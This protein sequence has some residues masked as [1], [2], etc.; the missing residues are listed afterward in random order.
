MIKLLLFQHIRD[1]NKD[2]LSFLSTESTQVICPDP[3][4]ADL[5]RNM[6]SSIGLEVITFND[7]IK[8]LSHKYDVKEEKKSKSEILF[9]LNLAHKQIATEDRSFSSLMRSYNLLSELRSVTLDSSVID[10]ILSLFDE[11][12]KKEVLS[13]NLLLENLNYFDEHSYLDLLSHKIKNEM[14]NKNYLFIGF[15]FFN[16]IQIDF[17]KTLSQVT[18]AYFA[19]P[20]TLYQK[21]SV[22]DWP[23]WLIQDEDNEV[24]ELSSLRNEDYKFYLFDGNINSINVDNHQDCL[25]FIGSHLTQENLQSL[26]SCEKKMKIKH[27][28]LSLSLEWQRYRIWEIWDTSKGSINL[29]IS[30]VSDELMSLIKKQQFLDIE[31]FKNFMTYLETMK[32]DYGVTSLDATD[33]LLLMELLELD[34]TR[35]SLHSMNTS[36]EYLVVTDLNSVES[37][38]ISEKSVMTIF[39]S[40]LPLKKNISLYKSE[41]EKFLTTIGPIKTSSFS[42]QLIISKVQTCLNQGARIYFEKDVLSDPDFHEIFPSYIK[43]ETVEIEKSQKALIQFSQKEGEL[44]KRILS[45]S[46][47]QTY[48]DCPLKFKMQYEEGVNYHNSFDHVISALED[49]NFLH[50]VIE[51]YMK[52]HTE[53]IQDEFEKYYHG[54][55]HSMFKEKRLSESQIKTNFLQ[56]KN[57]LIDNINFLYQIFD[58]FGLSD[59][60]FEKRIQNPTMNGIV[61]FYAETQDLIVLLD[62]K[63]SKSSIPSKKGLMSGEKIQLWFYLKILNPDKE[64]ILGYLS[65]E[66]I[67]DS[68]AVCS[69]KD[70]EMRWAE[71]ENEFDL[72]M[73]FDKNFTECKTESF[74]L[75]EESM[76]KLKSDHSFLALPRRDDVCQYCECRLFCSKGSDL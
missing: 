41:I 24:V 34:K 73:K 66:D 57:G 71:R 67:E 8:S 49:G 42:L 69:S 28:N 1:L 76:N 22:F 50:K 9:L 25:S 75:I 44:T 18:N 21:S 70:L 65:L 51:K 48:I 46:R 38:A 68:L 40:D 45:P 15:D 11:K 39:E 35:L 55:F 59:C 47:L 64:V 4:K 5:Y 14:E 53:F 54:I 6:L 27:D 52:N 63:R 12:T 33:V 60:D 37:H 17:F 23:A 31:F 30:S 19:L 62:F 2:N 74:N 29:F 58:T 16:S 26:A 13:M 61:D 56:Y 10:G 20:S 43:H 7:F 72:K 32:S 3:N 36:D